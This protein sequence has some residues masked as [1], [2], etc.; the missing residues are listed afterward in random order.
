MP[1]HPIAHL[2]QLAD[3]VS[4]TLTL[5]SLGMARDADGD[6]KLPRLVAE[7]ET[8]CQ[9]TPY[10]DAWRER[11]HSAGWRPPHAELYS[12]RFRMTS[13]QLYRVD[14]RFPRLV[15]ASFNGQQPPAGISEIRYSVKPSVV[16]VTHLV[17]SEPI[18][19]HTILDP[20]NRAQISHNP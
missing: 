19:A 15:R 12:R 14:D 16:D 8:L 4:G 13:Q 3:P 5:F 6:V 10:L 2:D 18:A 1:T 7:A 9:G 11:I 20:F 17:A